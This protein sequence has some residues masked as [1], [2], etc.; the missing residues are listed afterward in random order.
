MS[1]QSPDLFGTFLQ[2][3]KRG[4]GQ[5]SVASSDSSEDPATEILAYINDHGQDDKTVDL[6]KMLKDLDGNT[7]QILDTIQQLERFGLVVSKQ[8]DDGQ[9]M[10]KLK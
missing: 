8:T 7:K 10:L 9:P 6:R 4:K 1:S 3:T 2:K 5:E